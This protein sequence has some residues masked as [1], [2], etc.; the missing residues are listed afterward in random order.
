MEARATVAATPRVRR[1]AVAGNPNSGKSTLFN[2]LTG[3]RQRVGNYP[4]VTVERHEG[5]FTH[6]G[7]EVTL[8]DL[9]GIYSISARSPDEEVSR[10]VLL[11]RIDGVARPDGV[12]IVVD[13]SNLERNLYLA[14]QILDLGLPA[15]IACNMVDLAEERGERI[16]VTA[17]A[18]ELGVPVVATVGVRR[19]GLDALRQALVEAGVARRE[20]WP[21]PGTLEAAIGVVADELVASGACAASAAWGMAL[22]VMGETAAG[23]ED[24][25]G[26]APSIRATIAAERARLK[27]EGIADVAS[28]LVEARYAWIGDVAARS[29]SR[30]AGEDVVE[31][32]LSD[33]IDRVLTHKVFGTLIFAGV[34]FAMFVSIFSW[35]EPLMRLIEAGQEY[36]QVGIHR[37]LP[38]GPVADLLADGIVGGAGAVVVFL[39]Q[40]CILFLFIALLEDSG[41]MA[42]AAFLMDR[43]MSAAGLHGKSFIP[44]LSSYACAVPGIMAT[45]TIENPR[46]RLATILVAPLMSCSAR[47]PVYLTVI[48]AVFAGSVWVKAWVIFSMYL[49]GTVTA[50]LMAAVFK[51]TLLRGPTPTFIM[52]L[53]PYHL[54]RPRLILRTMWDRSKLFLTRAG[55][56]IVAVCVVL[57]ALAYFPRDTAAMA[58][59]ESARARATLSGG[60]SAVEQRH[61]SLRTIDDELAGAQLR[62]SLLGRMGKAIEPVLAP[63]GFD[64]RVGVGVLASFAAREVFVST[65]GVVFNAGGGDDEESLRKRMQTSVW[66]SGP[67]AGRRLFTPLSGISLMVFYVLCCQCASTLAVIGRETNSWR[68]PVFAF[69]YMTALA[70]L[71]SL[72]VY[73]VG[74]RMGI[75]P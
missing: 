36:L 66:D 65:M 43:L 12:L 10:D 28:A 46:D 47:L 58:R 41:Y 63:L 62:H 1:I 22:L 34:M 6:D 9:P 37:W 44:L 54:P 4:G 24:R 15:V 14:T 20:A 74:M 21:L 50:L 8:V 57:W 13:S 17:L 45:R 33:R 51:K 67:R 49:I 39:P 27:A 75:G 71:A 68:W 32:T 59:A 52:E 40:I 35:A 69:G 29:V 26:L 38:A 31:D 56:V 53:P 16:D 18:R 23:G 25:W 48:A 60:G 64:W 19:S 7:T 2:A 3:L 73:Q 42:R 70:Y 61:A 30:A 5:R 72:L 55:T 11:G